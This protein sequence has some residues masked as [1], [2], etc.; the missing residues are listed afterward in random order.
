MAPFVHFVVHNI[1][2]VALT[3]EGQML[4]LVGH[5]QGIQNSSQ[6][7]YKFVLKTTCFV[8]MLRPC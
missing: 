1:R 7:L 4:L 8:S 6:I 2:L 5:S 3:T